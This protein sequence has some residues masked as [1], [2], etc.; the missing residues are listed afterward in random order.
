MIPAR[1][2]RTEKIF[3]TRT[4]LLERPTRLARIIHQLPQ[5]IK[6]M[7][8]LKLL[9]L[10][11]LR[12]CIRPFVITKALHQVTQCREKLIHRLTP[13]TSQRSMLPETICRHIIRRA[14]F[15]RTIKIA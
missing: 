1:P 13:S 11:P 4:N 12:A 9:I 14:L 10:L 15:S 7:T 3:Q 5:T 6:K 8:Q 2:C